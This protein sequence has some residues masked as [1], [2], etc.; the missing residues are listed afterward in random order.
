MKSY[1][2]FISEGKKGLTPAGNVIKTDQA[3]SMKTSINPI[4]DSLEGLRRK[5]LDKFYMKASDEHKDTINKCVSTVVYC[6]DKKTR[7][8]SD[9]ID[10]LAKTIGKNKEDVVKE[11]E[12]E[13]NDFYGSR[14]NLYGRK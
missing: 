4:D 1:L 13:T 11:I 2:D 8:D 3:G 7:I 10:L 14:D 6:L 5:L 9:I 12:D